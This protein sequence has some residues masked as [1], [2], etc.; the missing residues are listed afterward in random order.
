[1]ATFIFLL[2]L[3]PVLIVVNAVETTLIRRSIAADNLR[4]DYAVLTEQDRM[5]RDVHDVLGHS[6]TA[7]GLKAELAERLLESDVDAAR[8]ELR[9]I[10]ALTAEAMDSIRATV[11]GLR[12]TTLS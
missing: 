10:R 8:A 12:R 3:L 11:G 9:Q 5:A 6:L 2:I 7:V 1:M 4:L